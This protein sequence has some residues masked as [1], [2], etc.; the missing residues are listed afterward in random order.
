MSKNNNGEKFIGD[1]KLNIENLFYISKSND[2][3]FLDDI[4][5][6]LSKLFNIEKKGSENSKQKTDYIKRAPKK[7]SDPNIR[8]VRTTIEKEKLTI[9]EFIEKLK[10]IIESLNDIIISEKI[11]D[12]NR[13]LISSDTKCF[14][15]YGIKEDCKESM[16]NLTINEKLEEI[17]E[18]GDGVEDLSKKI[19]PLIE[20]S[21]KKKEITKDLTNLT[22]T[23][24]VIPKEEKRRYDITQ[25]I[26]KKVLDGLLTK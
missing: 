5:T 12:K 7:F 23:P 26:I 21:P 25:S 18:T 16:E 10:K 1:I 3:K 13:N 14:N 6:S 11:Y 20:G 9:K 15:K 8:S 24:V 22:H 17:L 2:N 19:I 4:S